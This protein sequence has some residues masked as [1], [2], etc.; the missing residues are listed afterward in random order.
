ML[1]DPLLL[2]ITWGN[3]MKRIDWD[4]IADDIFMLVLTAPIW[5]IVGTGI[6]VLIEMLLFRAV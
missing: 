1:L 4:I 6:Y 5:V 2:C 3:K